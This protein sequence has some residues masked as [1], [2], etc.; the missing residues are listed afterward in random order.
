[1]QKRGQID[2]KVVMIVL[3]CAIVSLFLILTYDRFLVVKDKQ[4]TVEILNL[5]TSIQTRILQQS[6]KSKG[7]VLNTSF[8]VPSTVSEVCFFDANAK[9][10]LLKNPEISG[11]Y[12]SDKKNNLFL[13]TEKGLFAYDIDK[14]MLEEEYNPLCLKII[15]N[16]VTVQLDSSGQY[17]FVS[18][19]LKQQ[20][21]K[22][23]SVLE[24]G[25]PDDKVDIVF[26]LY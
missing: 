10:S 17:S 5:K 1:M 9:Y 4:E 15:N 20:Q 24:N 19:S 2:I 23:I 8:S 16:R 18:G 21:T 25:H 13:K 3:I 7:T 6:V 11:L 26:F 12:F 22:C 14:L